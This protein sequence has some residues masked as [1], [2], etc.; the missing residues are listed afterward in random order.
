MAI[1]VSQLIQSMLGAATGAAKG[2]G[3]DLKNYL[4]ARARLI[5]EGVA[6]IASDRLEGKINDDDVR[7]AFDEIKESE[8]TAA[9]AVS[10]TVKAAAQDA[11][12]AALNVAASAINSAIGIAI[13]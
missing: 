13:L 9:A 4:Q 2:H 12:N 8:K 7:F 3:A 11:V 1:N 10:V 5:A 6:A